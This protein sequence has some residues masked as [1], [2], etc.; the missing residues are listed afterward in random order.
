MLFTFTKTFL[1]T[2]SPTVWLSEKAK[3]SI[4]TSP[5]LSILRGNFTETLPFAGTDIMR[6]GPFKRE[7]PP[8]RKRVTFC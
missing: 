8:G 2:A 6:V 7:F 5:S 1:C 3:T 4:G